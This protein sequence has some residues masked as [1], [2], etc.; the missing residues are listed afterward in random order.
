M[1]PTDASMACGGCAAK[2]GQKPLA[3]ALGR[4]PPRPVDA[5]IQIGPEEGDDAAIITV[6][7]H[8]TLASV[9]FFRAFADDPWLVGRVAAVS[10]LSDIY[11]M[12]GTPRFAMVLA[13]LPDVHES[14]VERDL[15]QVMAGVRFALDPLGVQ[16]AGGHSSLGQQLA[17]GLSVSGGLDGGVKPLTKAGAT[18]GDALIL[19]KAL[20]TGIL[21]AA[22]MRGALPGGD[23]AALVSA[24]TRPNALA[25][26][27]ARLHGATAMTD[28]TGFG[29]IGHGIEMGRA[30]RV[31]IELDLAAL[32]LLPGALR[33][34]LTGMR[35]TYHL[36]NQNAL[37]A[38]RIHD[39]CDP[40]RLAL[41][42][43]PQT[44]GGLLIS[45]PA[46]QAPQLVRAAQRDNDGVYTV[47]GRVVPWGGA[48]LVVQ[49][50]AAG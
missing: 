49:S 19:T 24:L 14:R 6:D 9:D 45:C 44:S 20:G 34:A 50:G 32:P 3:N 27:L 33:L 18:P 48:P 11:A 16:L 38:A 28:V 29:L 22:A 41:A 30:S 21:L 36:Q 47:V 25:S 1:V 26:R 46:D 43:D 42:V 5:A 4:L 31:T 35:S 10:A 8:T 2:V 17:V 37:Q 15:G 7:G 40:A 39:G 23:Y 13:Q 12:G